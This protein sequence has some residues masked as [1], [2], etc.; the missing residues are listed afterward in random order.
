MGESGSVSWNFDRRWVLRFEKSDIDAEKLEEA[1]FET[2]A[3]DMLEEW[4]QVKVITDL[5]H[6]R[7]VEVSLK[8]AWFEASKS[9]VEHVPQTMNEITEF[10]MALKIIKMIEA[11]DED[12][13]VQDIFLN[14]DIDD[15]LQ[16]EVVEYI[17]KHSF[18]T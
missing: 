15:A 13:D 16:E 2:E 3:L 11:F 6:M 14:A 17:E 4:E 7:D 5:E 8:T 10:D 12:E 18:K 9:A 1:I